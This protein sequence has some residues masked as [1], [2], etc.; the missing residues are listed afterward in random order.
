MPGQAQITSVEA[1]EAFRS[2]LIVFLTQIK[3]VVDEVGGEVVRMKFWLENDQR[4][5]LENQARQRRRRFEEAQAEVFNARLSKLQESS[6]LQQMAAQKALRAVEESEQKLGALKK[7]DRDLENQTDP[8]V[9]QVAQLQS[10]LTNDLARAVAYLTQVIQTLEAY[11][12]VSPSGT[13]TANLP[14]ADDSPPT[15]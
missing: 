1:L 4:P 10:F 2:D 9:K 8:L 3:P 6:M 14:P 7:W 13:P 5:V 15:P 12:A 11:R